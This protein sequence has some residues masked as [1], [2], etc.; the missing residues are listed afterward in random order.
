VS[1]ASENQSDGTS[2]GSGSILSSGRLITVWRHKCCTQLDCGVPCSPYYVSF[3]LTA[4]LTN[5]KS[6]RP[7]VKSATDNTSNSL[8]QDCLRYTKVFLQRLFPY[9]SVILWIVKYNSHIIEHFFIFQNVMV[10]FINI[11]SFQLRWCAY[12]HISNPT[13]VIHL[14]CDGTYNAN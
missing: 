9:D 4:G 6:L 7:S 8:K 2:N 3:T 13:V 5:I 14:R 11:S 1:L 12:K 10:D